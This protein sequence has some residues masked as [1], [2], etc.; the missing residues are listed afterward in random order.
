MRDYV[1]TCF[2]VR[3]LDRLCCDLLSPVAIIA[4][5]YGWPPATSTRFAARSERRQAQPPADRQVPFVPIGADAC[6]PDARSTGCLDGVPSGVQQ[7]DEALEWPRLV[8][9]RFLLLD[10]NG[11]PE[12]AH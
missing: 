5:A 11:T 10:V 2:A 12:S 6:Q 1:I 4:S 7:G 8:Q 3:R 9:F